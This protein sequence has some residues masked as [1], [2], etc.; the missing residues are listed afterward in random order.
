M[1]KHIMNAGPFLK[2]EILYSITLLYCMY[3]IIAYDT[4]KVL[5]YFKMCHQP[6]IEKII[7]IYP[8]VIVI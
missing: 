8:R 2:Q 7:Q 3:T 1:L 6:K 4:Q 5:P